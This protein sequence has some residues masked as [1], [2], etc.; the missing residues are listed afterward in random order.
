MAIST[1]QILDSLGDYLDGKLVDQL[2]SNGKVASATLL[3][4]ITH[5]VRETLKGVEVV[6]EMAMYGKYVTEGRK[7]GAKGVPIQV[8]IDWIR[9]KKIESDLTRS[10]N[11]AFAMQ[12]SIKERGIKPFPF[13]ENAIRESIVRINDDVEEAFREKIEHELDIIFKIAA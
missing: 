11:I 13:I 10:R 3:N 4:S 12:K 1:R 8:L 6:G 7:V 5:E 9:L 2:V